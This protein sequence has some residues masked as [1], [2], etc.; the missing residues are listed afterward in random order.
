[1]KLIFSKFEGN[2][3]WKRLKWYSSS[4]QPDSNFHSAHRVGGRILKVIANT[5]YFKVASMNRYVLS[6]CSHIKCNI[7]STC[8][9]ISTL[10]KKN[11]STFIKPLKSV[12][13]MDRQTAFSVI[14]KFVNTVLSAW[15]ANIWAR[16]CCNMK[17]SAIIGLVAVIGPHR[18]SRTNLHKGKVFHIDSCSFRE[19][20]FKNNGPQRYI[21]FLTK[22][23]QTF[24]DINNFCWD[25]SVSGSSRGLRN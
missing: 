1:M 5:I 16:H 19:R 11:I 24:S 4:A 7:F 14:L 22:A 3:P 6:I 18:L 10:L 9:F 25:Q 15:N 23:Y 17:C 21:R 2:D 8:G 12:Q 13:F 20:R